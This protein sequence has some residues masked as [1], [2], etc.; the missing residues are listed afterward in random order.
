MAQH[1]N[2]IPPFWPTSIYEVILELSPECYPTFLDHCAQ[3]QQSREIWIGNVTLWVGCTVCWNKNTETRIENHYAQVSKINIT[4]KGP[5]FRFCGPAG[6]LICPS[7]TFA[8]TSSG[9]WYYRGPGPYATFRRPCPTPSTRWP[10][11]SKRAD[12]R[13]PPSPAGYWPAAAASSSRASRWPPSS[14]PCPLGESANAASHHS[15]RHSQLYSSPFH[16]HHRTARPPPRAAAPGK[17]PAQSSQGRHSRVSHPY[18]PWFGPKSRQ[19]SNHPPWRRDRWRGR[20]GTWW[21][22]RR[23]SGRT[24]R[25]DHVVPAPH[26]DWVVLLPPIHC[27]RSNSSHR[28]GKQRRHWVGASRSDWRCSQVRWSRVFDCLLWIRRGPFPRGTAVISPAYRAH[29][30]WM[31]HKIKWEKEAKVW[32]IVRKKNEG[33]NFE[34]SW[35]WI[36]MKSVFWFLFLLQKHVRLHVW[37]VIY[38]SSYWSNNRGGNNAH[39]FSS[40]VNWYF[41]SGAIS[42]IWGGGGNDQKISTNSKIFL[43]KYTIN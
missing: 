40:L 41:F 27:P 35:C 22:G 38:G 17:L 26:P 18:D 43:V 15:Q 7:W 32:K 36:D 11:T 6:S 12:G 5:S 33:R 23:C 14:C 24:R 21:H 25:W 13:P 1:R 39:L 30:W 8:P 4:L 29:P 34:P 3:Q 19:S 10:G 9:R 2:I 16:S 20:R 31:A 37:V 28:W 42:A